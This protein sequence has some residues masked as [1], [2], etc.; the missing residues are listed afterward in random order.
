[1]RRFHLRLGCVQCGKGMANLTLLSLYLQ[2]ERDVCAS[3]QG[4]VSMAGAMLRTNFPQRSLVKNS[5]ECCT[6]LM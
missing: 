5:G 2:K 3:R 1:M 6:R 4:E